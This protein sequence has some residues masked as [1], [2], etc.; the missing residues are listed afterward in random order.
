ME[1]SK[2]YRMGNPKDCGMSNTKDYGME[3]SK[4]YRMGNPKDYGMGNPKDYGVETKGL[5]DGSPNDYG[6][7]KQRIMG[8]GIHSIVRWETQRIVG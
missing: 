6:V 3:N 8:W 7:G 2:Y 5:R 4:Y 1:N